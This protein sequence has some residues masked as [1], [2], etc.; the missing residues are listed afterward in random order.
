[1]TENLILTEA[2]SNVLQN[3]VVTVLGM[4]V[5]NPH[6]FSNMTF[7]KVAREVAR[8]CDEQLHYEQYGRPN[9]D[10][11]SFTE[12]NPDW[13]AIEQRTIKLEAGPLLY[14]PNEAADRAA[15]PR[16]EEMTDAEFIEELKSGV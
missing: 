10:D 6:A 5:D 12:L 4:I 1:M 16:T 13:G 15:P 8:E 7:K 2:Q 9:L 3:A 11:P 14:D